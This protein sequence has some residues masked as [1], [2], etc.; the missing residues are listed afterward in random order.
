M[1][2]SKIDIIGANQRLTVAALKKRISESSVLDQMIEIAETG[3]IYSLD[4]N[5]QQVC[6][7]VAPGARID[8]MKSLA[9]KVLPNA[10]ESQ[11][12]DGDDHAKWIEL[13]NADNLPVESLPVGHREERRQ[14]AKESAVDKASKD[15]DNPMI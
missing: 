5:G 12:K 3:R 10:K 9:G 15:D 8:V 1:S 2:D 7:S 11:E 14:L 4:E 6:E 13:A